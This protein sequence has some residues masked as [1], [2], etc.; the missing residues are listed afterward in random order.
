MATYRGKDLIQQMN[1]VVVSPGCLA[2]W[3]LGQMGVALKGSNQK[4]VYIDPILSDV[5]TQK[6]PEMAG[7]M[8]RAF[9][10]P[11][12]P[13][14]VNNADF[15]FCTHEHLDHTD[16]L[17]L[18]PLAKA[19]PRAR[20]VISGWAQALLDEAEIAADRRLIPLPGKALELD[21]LQ[22]RSIP[23]AHYQVE[24]DPLKGSRW[25]SLLVSWGDAAF[26]HSG[27]TLI[28]PGYLDAIRQL[29]QADVGMVAANG[30][31]AMREAQDILG[32]LLPVEAAWMADEL[33]WDVLL[34]G[35]NDLF[36][37]NALPAGD[38]FEAA[39]RQNAAQKVHVL[40]PG[41][42]YYYIR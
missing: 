29:P 14:E 9:P 41:E 19:S 26:F 4:I 21:G 10:P 36:D 39:Q 32:N 40:R 37:Y 20:F 11:L 25:M 16:P 23:A 33:G 1:A 38:L 17:T 35:H 13:E 7:V 18:G 28:Y 30:R 27:D 15:V 6:I 42:L 5:V 2:I 31:N 22:V 3:G 8:D 12:K 24:L 34:G